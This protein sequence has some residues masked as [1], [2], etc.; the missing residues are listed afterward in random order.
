MTVTV[1]AK[2]YET[3]PQVQCN[4]CNTRPFCGGVHRI[5]EHIIHEAL[6]LQDKLQK[7]GYKAKV[8]QWDTDSDSD[9]SGDDDKDLVA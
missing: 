7:S 3:N 4:N 2:E 5:K 1:I 9:D 8:A 6:H